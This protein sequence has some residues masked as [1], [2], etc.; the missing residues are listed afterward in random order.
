MVT[1]LHAVMLRVMILALCLNA[2]PQ[3]TASGA[4]QED[5][6]QPVVH[7][8]V[9]DHFVPS[10]V[11][12]Q[13]WDGYL[14][15]RMRINVEKRLLALDLDSILDP[16]EHRPGKQAWVG[17][18]VGKW[19][20][21]ACLSWKATGNEQLKAEMDR[22]VRR[23]IATQL[24][25]GYL[26]TYV[27]EKRWTEW[28]VWSHKYNLIG[29]LS[30]YR[31]TGDE[32]SLAACR[33]V[34]DL[35]VKTFGTGPDQ[36]D[37]VTHST[38][39]GMAA[40]SVLEPMVMLYRYTGA[41]SYL[42]FCQYIVAAWEQEHGPR[43]LW[44]LLENEGD[45][46]RT[47]NNKAYEMMSC[48][49]G[50]LDL[51]RLTGEQRLLKAVQLAWK[52]LVTKRTYIIGSSSWAEHFRD[53]YDLYADG[54][55][56]GTK[57]CSCCEGCVTVTW[58]QLNWH[59]LR[60][61]GQ[62]RYA[63]ELERTTYNALLGAQ[64]P[65]TGQVTYFLPLRGDRK[66]YGEVT[67]G[68]L[69]DVCCCS[70]SIPRGIALIPE[71]T[72]GTIDHQPALL[73]YKP[74]IYTIPQETGPVRLR[75]ETDY[76]K[77]GTVTVG[78]QPQRTESFALVLHVPAWCEDF[79]AVVGQ[80]TYQG[81]SG[82]LLR[83]DR[84]WQP[85]EQVRIH[86]GMPLK[87]L[88][89]GRSYPGK[90]A[91]KRGPQVLATDSTVTDNEGKL[92][93]W[94]WFGGQLYTVRGATQEGTEHTLSMVPFAEAGQARGDY[95]VWV[96]KFAL[97]SDSR[98]LDPVGKAHIPIG[99]PNSLDSLKT[100]VEA[101]GNFSP[102]IG[103]Y[104][105]YFWLFDPEQGR[106]TAPTFK[107]VPCTHGL[108]EERLLIPWSQWSAGE[109][110]VR[111]E[112]CQVM[113]SPARGDAYVTGTRAHLTNRGRNP[114]TV[115]LYVAVRPLGPAGFDV[116]KLA[117]SDTG[118][119]LL[120]DDHPALI[121]NTLPAAAGVLPT[122][123]I[124]EL[125]LR[126]AMPA[127]RTAVSPEG[128][129]SGAL[130]FDVTIPAGDTKTVGLVCPVHAGR[131][132]V[133]HRWTPR[134]HN[135][136]D[137][138]VPKSD[139]DG[140]DI[141]DL[142]LASY[143]RITA[144]SLFE[145]ARDDWRRFY[146]RVTLQLPDPRWTNG[147]YAMLAHAALCMNEGA[148]DVAVLN[149][150]VF[151]RDGMY[152]AN[153]MQKAGLPRMSAAVIDYFLAHPFNGRP[154]PEADNPGQVLWSIG[155]HWRL[156]GDRAWLN[157]VYPSALR[158]AE[159]IRY[160]RMEPGPHSVNLNSL[161]YGQALAPQDRME[162]KPGACDG[163][164][165]EYTEAFDIVGLRVVGKLAEA[166][167]QAEQAQQWRQLADRLF[168]QYDRRFGENLGKGYGSYSVLWPCSL[169]P[170]HQGKAHDQFEGIGT[171]DLAMWRY[172]APATAHQGLLAGNRQAGYGT[173]D[174]HLAHP[175]MRHWYAFD[176]GGRSG[177][178]GWHHLR[179][180]WP[181]SKTKPDQN[182]AV[183]MPHGWAI[184]EVW[185]LMRDCIVYERDDRLVLLSGVSP[186][187]F[188]SPQGM[189]VRS[190]PTCFGE[191]N[192]QWKRTPQGAVLRLGDRARPAGGF[193]LRLPSNL[194]ARVLIAGKAVSKDST[195]GY[196]LPHGPVTAEIEFHEPL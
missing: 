59:L 76:P 3:R 23:L 81:R 63:G 105:V 41:Q 85:T 28:D 54:R 89:G 176:E 134:P 57:F 111:T 145:Q 8:A 97:S 158:M 48:L 136:I 183:A 109:I 46:F 64:S 193:D 67:H 33:K 144:D 127:T 10:A 171:R 32:A 61:T 117:V 26:G 15:Q 138:A 18:H 108:A 29:L 129:C 122:D 106:L 52:D 141:F 192:L 113:Q 9:M 6:P 86:M 110:T 181:H 71:F 167:G 163:F 84:S 121:A 99:I 17:E 173:V 100:F 125:A 182:R 62:A 47:A 36:L 146:S 68:I 75:V 177:S 58:M 151:N 155:Q 189:S 172:F 123:T 66:R 56:H 150:T 22:T 162:L 40:G 103:S 38:H 154:Y 159:M 126:G 194:A 112:V 115:S 80:R 148:P 51:Y 1:H 90:M 118:D 77:T 170:L 157:R 93:R 140:L 88:D 142:G 79:Q 21:A 185:L 49:V 161:A 149:Y 160:Y 131:R 60:L 74:G 107:H 187:W 153:M 35:L 132:A 95:D 104:G 43:L 82:S 98:Q 12:A 178:G 55:Y 24:P 25:D 91:L 190:L 130:R 128:D 87:V 4:G 186:D 184:A 180:T 96:D 147:F 195:G 156:T 92:P 78:V 168:E 70:S 31:L 169:Y 179:T 11:Q 139:A 94:G 2:L 42:H 196:R 73:L 175:Q 116:L 16:F 44:S 165:P 50:C 124:G 188:T 137:N 114:R 7:D 120:V 191:L 135:Y 119:A 45:V 65:H 164:H 101:E 34:G 19:L 27:T 83:I 53:D 5:W 14:G 166:M 20:H 152:I 39:V 102:G 69:P 72:A 30:Y 133:R 13:V 37:I 143:R 174:L